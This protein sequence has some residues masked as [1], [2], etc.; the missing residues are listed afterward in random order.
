MS[1]RPLP[2]RIYALATGLAE[3]IAPRLLRARA[4]RG[5]EDYPRLDERLG[6]PSAER[7]DGPLMWIHG[8]SVGESLSHLPLVE[9]MAQARPDVALLVTSGTLTSAELLAR[10]LPPGVAHQY[11]PIDAPHAARRFIRHW[12]PDLG[13]FV[14]SEL[15]PNL[16]W[17]ARSTGTRLALL[18]AR[19]SERSARR[20]NRAPKSAGALLRLFD[21]IYAQDAPTREWIESLGIEVAGRLSMKQAA[22]PLPC[23]PGVLAD[24]RQA[25]GERPVLV[26]ASTHRG[27]EGMLARTAAERHP[28]PLLVVV[29]RHPERGAE[30]AQLVAAEGW[31]VQRRSDGETLGPASDAYVADTLGELGLFYR[32]AD[33]VVMGGSFLE[34]MS[35][36]NPLEPARL[37]KPVVSG[38]HNDAFAETYAQLQGERAVLIA[39]D[40]REL[41]TALD[42]LLAEPALAR[43]LG[44][45]GRAASERGVDAFDRAWESLQQLLPPP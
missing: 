10:R 38:P 41:A 43:A 28:R 36:H 19:L 34:G 6:H 9:R 11:A 42:A 22:G 17:A 39:T 30:A 33:A 31:S 45:R 37:G 24:M 13:V 27:E 1:A 15:W 40:E 12:R 14:E 44:E 29:P 2:L 18:G 3:P 20:W 16:L 7:R 26:L 23:D 35:G 32:L 4:R 8:A 5:K 25:I 21:V